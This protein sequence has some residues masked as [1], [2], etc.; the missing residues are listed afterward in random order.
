M[1]GSSRPYR[2][3]LPRPLPAPS[4]GRKRPPVSPSRS[5]AAAAPPFLAEAPPQPRPP[6]SHAP[7]TPPPAN[8]GRGLALTW[9]APLCPPPR[10]GASTCPSLALALALA[11]LQGG[12]E[13]GKPK[14]AAAAALRRQ[15]C[16]RSGPGPALC[17]PRKGRAGLT[18]EPARREEAR[19]RR[20][21][22]QRGGARLPVSRRPAHEAA[23]HTASAGRLADLCSW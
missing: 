13:W 1:G 20:R 11:W 10:G 21:Q 4:R 7:G 19:G 8:L 14:A 18:R 6:A 12:G 2:E 9:R 23:S 15:K 16:P 3:A 17:A 22:Q 5:A